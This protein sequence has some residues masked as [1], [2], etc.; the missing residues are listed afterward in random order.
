MSKQST[1]P[2]TATGSA[3]FDAESLLSLIEQYGMEK[4]EIGRAAGR[5]AGAQEALAKAQA[6]RTWRQIR[7]MVLS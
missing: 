6:A 4:H 1:P 5:G 2:G 3:R 7:T